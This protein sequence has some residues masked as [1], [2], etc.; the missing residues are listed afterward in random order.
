MHV[1]N[2]IENTNSL[3]NWISMQEIDDTQQQQPNMKI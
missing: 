1:E 3:Y 2:S